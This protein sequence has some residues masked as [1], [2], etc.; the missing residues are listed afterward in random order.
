[1]LE[2]PPNLVFPMTE[3]PFVPLPWHAAARTLIDDARL[4]C[5]T[6]FLVG[7]PG[8]GKSQ[9]LLRYTQGH[10]D[11]ERA[12][13]EQSASETGSA[14]APLEPVP[15]ADMVFVLLGRANSAG[16]MFSAIMD[17]L[18]QQ[19][20]PRVKRKGTTVMLA[21]VAKWMAK[22]GVHALVLDEVQ[23]ASKEA[24]FH[25]M[26]LSDKCEH[27]HGHLLSLVLLGTPDA[28]EV[29]SETGQVGQ[30]VPIVMPVPLLEAEELTDVCNAFPPVARCLRSLTVRQREQ[31]LSEIVLMSA[32]SIRRLEKM[33]KR[34]VRL[35]AHAGVLLTAA[36]VRAAID[37]HAD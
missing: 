24:L 15:A 2:F 30:R 29:V 19:I 21:H 10:V 4:G 16:T 14:T 8:V 5:E 28:H 25:A 34:A 23:H 37:I 32:G 31:L 6:V 12:T 27:D 36:H 1:M 17:N 20:P 13:L 9:L 3:F 22:N 33:L 11:L 7:A 26:L 35:A 18:K